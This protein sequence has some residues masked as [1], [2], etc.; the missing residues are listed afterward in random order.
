MKRLLTAAIAVAAIAAF[1]SPEAR[2][3]STRRREVHVAA[4]QQSVACKV[5]EKSPYRLSRAIP[6]WCAYRSR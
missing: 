1:T 4:L 3:L 2:R 5:Q 6:D